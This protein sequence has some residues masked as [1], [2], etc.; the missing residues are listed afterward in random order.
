MQKE[1]EE[2]RTRFERQYFES[3]EESDGRIK[4]TYALWL[5]RELV[6]KLDL[7]DVNQQ[8]ELLKGYNKYLESYID[9]QYLDDDMVG[10]Y[11]NTL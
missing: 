9:T 8:R 5:E 2:I 3:C 4:N 11:I 10:N 1:L 6:K 7:T